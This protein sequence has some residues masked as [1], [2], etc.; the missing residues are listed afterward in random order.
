MKRHIVDMDEIHQAIM[1]IHSNPKPANVVTVEVIFRLVLQ[2]KAVMRML[3]YTNARRGVY[4][5]KV[6]S[7]CHMKC[8]VQAQVIG[9]FVVELV[10]VGGKLVVD[11]P[12]EEKK[13]QATGYHPCSKCG[14]KGNGSFHYVGGPNKDQPLCPNCM[15]STILEKKEKI[16][17]PQFKHDGCDE[18]RF[19]GHELGCDLYYCCQHRFPTLIARHSDEPS[20]YNSGMHSI[21]PEIVRARELAIEQGHIK[22]LIHDR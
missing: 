15:A 4:L 13:P 8:D 17:K 1:H 20:N 7:D 16:T 12:V 5:W 14:A 6:D 22:P 21:L 10:R 3:K 18:C 2:T 9:S 11:I 19:L